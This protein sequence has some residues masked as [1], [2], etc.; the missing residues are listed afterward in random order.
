MR[1][2]HRGHPALGSLQRARTYWLRG[3]NG[4]HLWVDS[5]K[6]IFGEGGGGGGGGGE[7]KVIE[8][9]NLVRV[10][11]TLTNGQRKRG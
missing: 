10:H 4:L 6:R 1:R 3:R 2:N 9:K 11:L 7:K 8:K 5:Q